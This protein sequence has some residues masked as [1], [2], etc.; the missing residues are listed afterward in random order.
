MTKLAKQNLD[1]LYRQAIE[2][3]E[4]EYTKIIPKGIEQII[5]VLERATKNQMVFTTSDLYSVHSGENE[6]VAILYFFQ[7]LKIGTLG[8]RGKKV[9][10]TLNKRAIQNLEKGGDYER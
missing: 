5:S 7:K 9:N 6:R 4:V 10:I 3:K 8:Y 1:L 2:N